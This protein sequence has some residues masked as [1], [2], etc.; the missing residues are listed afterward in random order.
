MQWCSVESICGNLAP[1]L[2]RRTFFSL[3]CLSILS[4]ILYILICM[5]P[6][7]HDKPLFRQKNSFISPFVSHVVLSSACHNTTFEI[8][9]GWMH[10]PSP[11]QVWGDCPPSPP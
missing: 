3:F 8:L 1:S 7:L 2:G 11:P 5:T 4:E 10:G 9:G 6:F